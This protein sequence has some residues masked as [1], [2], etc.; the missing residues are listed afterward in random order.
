MVAVGNSDLWIAPNRHFATEHEGGYPR[1]VSLKREN[2]QIE[3][4]PDMIFK[5]LRHPERA[6]H[7]H[8]SGGGLRVLRFDPL[9]AQFH[10]ANGAE[11]LVYLAAV[12][13][14]EIPFQ[15][16]HRSGDRIQD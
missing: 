5:L 11:I 6:S 8:C 13:R 4:Q 1:D 16:G 7:L 14:S 15:L 9:Q 3:H 10:L 12:A 2:L